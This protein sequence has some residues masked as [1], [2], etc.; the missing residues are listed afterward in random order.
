MIPTSTGGRKRARRSLRT[1]LNL[2]IREINP[3][4][5]TEHAKDVFAFGVSQS[6]CTTGCVGLYV[7][8]ELLRR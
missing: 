1:I 2:F 8:A 3:S 5:L 4:H 7:H 6:A